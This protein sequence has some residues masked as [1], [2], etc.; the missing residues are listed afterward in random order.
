MTLRRSYA[1]VVVVTSLDG[2]SDSKKVVVNPA[3]T[4]SVQLYINT[5][6]SRFNPGSKLI[7]SGYVFAPLA[8]TSVWS[9]LTPLGVPLPYK[10]L[11]PTATNFTFASTVGYIAFPLGFKAGTF[12]GGS[13]YSFRLTAYPVGNPKLATFNEVTMTANSPPTGGYLLVVPTSG[14]ALVTE[15]LIS[16]PGW[17]SNVESL[18]LKYSFSYTVSKLL[19]EYLTLATPSLK[20]SITT[21]LPAGLSAL[22]NQI[23]LQSQAIDYLLT[24]ATAATTVHVTL[25]SAI[26]L[27][28]TLNSTLTAALAVGNINQIYQAINTVRTPA[29]LHAKYFAVRYCVLL[30]LHCCMTMAIAEVPPQVHYLS[31]HSLPLSLLSYLSSPRRLRQQM[32]W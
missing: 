32:K 9:V 21:T 25:D 6:L 30:I 16:T 13:T 7:V 26:D 31:L 15:F 14:S 23:T 18:P 11:T 3:Y 28:L 2:R 20:A 29:L 19:S 17:T 4:G 27:S 24:S 10:A 1:F 22:S 8:V 12:A 5:T